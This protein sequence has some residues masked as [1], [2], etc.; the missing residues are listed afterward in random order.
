MVA[1]VKTG[2]DSSVPIYDKALI[3]SEGIFHD[4]YKELDLASF[5]LHCYRENV[6]SALKFCRSDLIPSEHFAENSAIQ[7]FSKNR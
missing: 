3:C 6:I 2:K 7:I 1:F 5:V 4:E